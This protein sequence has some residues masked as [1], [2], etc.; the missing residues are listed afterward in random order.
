MDELV[1][2]LELLL[3]VN[4][5]G[6]GRN[7]AQAIHDVVLN[8]HGSIAAHGKSNGITG[9][10]VDLA[11]VTIGQYDDRRVEHR[12]L[13]ANDLDAL[14]LGAQGA[15]SIE[16]QVMGNRAL[17]SAAIDATGYCL[18]TAFALLDQ[19]ETMQ[20]LVDTINAM[21]DLNMSLDDV[22][23]LGKDILRKERA[24]NAAAGFTK[25]HDRLP[26]YFSRESVAPHNVRWDVSDEDLD[27][28][29][30]F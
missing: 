4:F 29:F 11:L 17:G 7:S 6:V 5:L 24:F 8:K 3:V 18:F 25:A 28:V 10:G 19:P 15:N 13:G 1:E 9:T 20:A 2:L 26:L 30:N 23:E 14:E 21:Y 27:S 16:Q 22:T 12:R